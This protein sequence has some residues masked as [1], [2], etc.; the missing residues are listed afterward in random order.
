MF[1]VYAIKSGK[2]DRVYIGQSGCLE[3]RFDE[4]NA[5]RVS[6]TKNDR[7]WTLL[8]LQDFKTRSEARWF[9]RQLKQSRGRRL[10]WLKK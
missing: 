10:R 8:R 3:R 2:N 7:P 6:S 9:E 1:Y 5:G 4:H